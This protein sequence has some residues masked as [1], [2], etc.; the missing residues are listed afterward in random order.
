M[1]VSQYGYIFQHRIFA[2][3]TMKIE[4]RDSVNLDDSPWLRSP[5]GSL[6]GEL[7]FLVRRISDLWTQITRLLIFKNAKVLPQFLGAVLLAKTCLGE[8]SCVYGGS[9]FWQNQETSGITY[10]RVHFM[11][12]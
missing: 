4:Q 5:R 7:L 6:L 12:N 8:R 3:G 10:D 9:F 2:Q 11:V 1:I